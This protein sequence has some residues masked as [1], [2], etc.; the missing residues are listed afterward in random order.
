MACT[1]YYLTAI[2]TSCGSNIPSIKRIIVGEFGSTTINHDM[3]SSTASDYDDVNIQMKA[4]GT[5]PVVDLDGLHIIKDIIDC[6][7][8]AAGKEWVEFQFRKNT[9]NA[10]SEMTVNDNG[11]HYF[12]NALNMVFAK[13][14]W[15]KRLAIQALASGDCSV[16]YEDGNGNWWMLGLD[17]PVT[18]TT[19][20]S[21]TGV[22]V[23]DSNQYS[24]TMSED[25]AILP[26]PINAANVTSIVSKLLGTN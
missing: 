9:C 6:S 8:P 19:A 13:Q 26:V 17:N 5:T 11:T 22:A 1:A 2:N 12:T 14:D 21:D 7:S 4:D 24:L 3:A 15:Q 10:T 25:S 23:G 16:V 20:S 18:L